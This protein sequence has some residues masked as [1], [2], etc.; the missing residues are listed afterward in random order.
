MNRPD[1]LDSIYLN[2][3]GHEQDTQHWAYY[4]VTSLGGQLGDHIQV[5]LL[6]WPLLS[7]IDVVGEEDKALVVNPADTGFIYAYPNLCK[8]LKKK[9]NIDHEQS[10]L[11]GMRVRGSSN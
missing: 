4:R 10:I 2:K 11:I 3:R 8:L 6:A 1:V 9:W 5:C 7:D